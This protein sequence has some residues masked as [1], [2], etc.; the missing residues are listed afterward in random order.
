MQ[1]RREQI[2]RPDLRNPQCDADDPSD[3]EIFAVN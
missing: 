3:D 1:M 2:E